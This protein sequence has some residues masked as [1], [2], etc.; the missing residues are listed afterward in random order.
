[1]RR[2]VIALCVGAL[3]GYWLGHMT[4]T[5]APAARYVRAGPVAKLGKVEPIICVGSDPYDARYADCFLY[6]PAGGGEFKWRYG[7]NI[8][9][10]KDNYTLKQNGR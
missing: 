3:Y 7:A 2:I 1:M 8:Q 9:V 4:R 5:V 10:G 6:P